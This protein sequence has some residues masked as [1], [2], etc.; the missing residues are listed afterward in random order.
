MQATGDV[1]VKS[2]AEA[3]ECAAVLS[4]GLGVA[5]KIDDG[6]SRASAPALIHVLEQIDGL[7]AAH[8]RELAVPRR[9]AGAGRRQARRV[10]RGRLRPAAGR[11]V[12]GR[13]S[14]IRIACAAR[15]IR[16]WASHA[17]PCSACTRRRWTS[18]A[19]ATPAA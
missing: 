2:G 18:R 19:P 8:L 16:A 13:G 1:V 6:G 10:A 4:S 11:P 15:N 3:L 12:S 7:T 9:A 17:S 14:G 5:V